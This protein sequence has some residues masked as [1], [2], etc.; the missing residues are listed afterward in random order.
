MK[1]LHIENI[2]EFEDML[3]L[4]DMEEYEGMYEHAKLVLSL[5]DRMTHVIDFND[6]IRFPVIYNLS[7]PQIDNILCDEVQDFSSMQAELIHKLKGRYV[8]VGDKHQA[9]YGF[10]GAMSNSMSFLKGY[11]N[12][13]ELPLSLTYRCPKLVVNEARKLFDDIEALDDA[14]DG[15]VRYSEASKES[16]DDTTLVVCRNN[17]PLI[18]LAYRLLRDG[19]PCHVKGRDIAEGLTR[20]VKKQ[21]AVTVKEL[22][23]KL[24]DWYDNETYKARRKDNEAKLQS[25]EDKYRSL[26]VFTEGISLDAP[27]SEV[28]ERIDKLFANGKG[29]GTI[30]S[31]IHKAKGLEAERVFIL[32]KHLMPAPYAKQEWQKEQEKNIEYVAITRSKDELV[33]M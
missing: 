27:P 33:Y 2:T 22:I 13:V 9:I 4:H 14:K 25:L 10:R 1:H 3:D 30:L 17:A 31:T 7:M 24:D 8:L 19:K 18:S 28:V 23:D 15:V 5:S 16:Y 32:D 21:D 11:F 29:K 6:Q 12:C 20:L 26:L